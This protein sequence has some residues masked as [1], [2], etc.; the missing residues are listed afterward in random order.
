MKRWIQATILPWLPTQDQHHIK[1]VN[2]L[3]MDEGGGSQAPFIYEELLAVN[4]C[5]EEGHPF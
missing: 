4:G 2:D 5:W 1:P 3:R